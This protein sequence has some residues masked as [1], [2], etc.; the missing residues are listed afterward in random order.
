MAREPLAHCQPVV[1]SI[2]ASSNARPTSASSE[3]T[4]F[5]ND[6]MSYTMIPSILCVLC[7]TF[8]DHLIKLDRTQRLTRSVILFRSRPIEAPS[9]EA[10]LLPE[11]SNQD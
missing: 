9:G 8:S 1:R 5:C 4:T 7:Y 2:L 6:S 3:L 10:I 11:R